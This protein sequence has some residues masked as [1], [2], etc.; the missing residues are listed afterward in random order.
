MPFGKFRGARIT[1]VPND[2]LSWLHANLYLR[3]PLRS[4]VELELDLRNEARAFSRHKP[5]EPAFTVS[6]ADLPVLRQIIDSGYRAVART[7]HPDTGGRAVDMVRLNAVVGSLR[8]Q[9]AE[10]AR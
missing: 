5:G 8:S 9:L 2:Y 4:A 3:E 6:A 7:S 10:A 1:E